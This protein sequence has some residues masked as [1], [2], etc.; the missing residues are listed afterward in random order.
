MIILSG[1][2]DGGGGDQSASMPTSTPPV[3]P[4]VSFDSLAPPPSSTAEQ[5][6][7][8]APSP[9]PFCKSNAA[10]QPENGNV[11]ANLLGKD[12]GMDTEE[13]AGAAAQAASIATDDAKLSV[14]LDHNNNN[15]D[16]DDDDGSEYENDSDDDLIV[17]FGRQTA[18]SGDD[19]TNDAL[20]L[21]R[22][23]DLQETP[24][25]PSEYEEPNDDLLRPGDHVYSW[26]KRQQRHGIVLSIGD[27]LVAEVDPNDCD[28]DSVAV[29][30]FYNK[31]DRNRRAGNSNPD[32]GCGSD[33]NDADVAYSGL[34]TSD[35]GEMR[36]E[37]ALL[38]AAGETQRP[39]GLGSSDFA[40]EVT[41]MSL[42]AFCGGNEKKN[43][44]CKV[45]YGRNLAKRLLSRPGSVTAV[46]ADTPGLVLARVKFLL[47][48]PGSLPEYHRM[49]ANGECAAVFCKIGRFIT[50]QGSSILQIMFFGQ[51]GGAVTGGVVAS[52]V[53]LWTPVPGIWGAM[54]WWWYVPITVAYPIVVPL[55]VTFGLASLLPLEM[56]RRYRNKWKKHTQELNR[57][58][59]THT[60]DD[61]K[62]EYFGTTATADE[63][64]V[65]KFF[66]VRDEGKE[67][68]DNHGQ[69]M[70][71][72]EGGDE[73]EG[74]DEL[75]RKYSEN[76]ASAYEAEFC[77]SDRGDGRIK[78][79][80]NGL[81]SRWKRGRQNMTDDDL[82]GDDSVPLSGGDVDAFPQQ[83]QQQQ[84]RPSLMR[85]W[86]DS[87]T[88]RG[89]S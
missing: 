26:V 4:H 82:R 27:G 46:K 58:F 80:M 65:R 12:E 32:T 17:G 10:E 61:T 51:A 52:H 22:E 74:D 66:G 29:V 35:A 8:A 37:G 19:D 64:W 40:S 7:A 86:R 69:Y 81:L 50:L 45:R 25:A 59:W 87:W 9:N 34:A 85:K 16:D 3:P 57:E 28:M 39:S 6:E 68:E 30:S 77:D 33:D 48:H 67:D 75:E 73:D 79:Q 38:D 2:P 1:N 49:A 24:S 60:D 84:R 42:R 70:P 5:V 43:A 76:M 56:L 44:V 78:M 20:L 53:F 31:K 55:L 72:G 41:E 36:D 11:D 18:S 47:D 83:Q 54:G 71:V 13:A 63:D 88:N 15:G 21:P 23:P 14:A 89:S 62:A